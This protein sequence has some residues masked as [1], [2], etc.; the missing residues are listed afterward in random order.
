[1]GQFLA[2]DRGVLVL[3]LASEGSIGCYVKFSVLSWS[4]A[5][6]SRLRLVDFGHIS[7]FFWH[8]LTILGGFG[9]F[10][11]FT[12]EFWSFFWYLSGVL[13]VV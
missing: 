7:V 4:F 3:L 2:I 8:F 10:W 13:A 1:M 11:L 5:S 6:F 12:G 9:D